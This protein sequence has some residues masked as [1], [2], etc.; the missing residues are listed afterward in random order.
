MPTTRRRLFAATFAGLCAAVVAAQVQ[1]AQPP[2]PPGRPAAPAAEKG[3]TGKQP[4]VSFI[5]S[6]SAERLAGITLHTDQES[7]E[8]VWARHK[9]EKVE[10][11]SY[12]E[13]IAPEIDFSAC[14]AVAIFGGQA[15]NSRGLYVVG[16]EESPERVLLRFDSRSYQTASFGDKPDRGNAVTPYG[17]FVIPRTAKPLVIEEDTQGLIGQPPIWTERA[18]FPAP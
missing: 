15:V 11:D 5:G 18:R 13:A 14:V 8:K 12:G 2:R 10:K 4:L 7:W 1:T 16:I 3:W 9:G 17:L 6:Y